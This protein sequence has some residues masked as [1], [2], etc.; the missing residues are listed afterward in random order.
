MS[1]ALGQTPQ[2]ATN[3]ITVGSKAK[4]DVILA[5]A[6]LDA[7]Q[8]LLRA[9]KRPRGRRIAFIRRQLQGYGGDA[10]KRFDRER[11]VLLR[12]GWQPNQATYD[13]MR[14]VA[15]NYYA[16]LGMRA[17]KVAMSERYG[18]DHLVGLGADD[19]KAIGCG[20]TGGVTVVGS[21]VAGIYGGGA[22]AGAVGAGGS[23]VGSALD[24]NAG[25]RESQERIAAAQSAQ[26]Q[27]AADAALQT[28]QAQERAAGE[29]T[30]QIK[31]VALVAG[32]L[33]LVLGVGYA[34]VKV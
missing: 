10:P 20:I 12:R 29:R 30:K 14:L 2:R 5:R 3:S 11:A 26:A 25:A 33:I 31:A 8:I 17:I 16:A 18:A 34:I 1:Y 22:G 19:A 4:D 28:A 7:S 21:L 13:A 24:C 15:S 9:A 6:S 23:I 27:A 32:G